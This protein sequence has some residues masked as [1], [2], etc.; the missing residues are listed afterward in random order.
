MTR[1]R[2]DHA[3]TREG[4]QAEETYSRARQLADSVDFRIRVERKIA[5][6]EWLVGSLRTWAIVIATLVGLNWMHDLGAATEM[7]DWWDGRTEGLLSS[8]TEHEITV[9]MPLLLAG[10]PVLY[11]IY[12]D[13]KSKRAAKAATEEEKA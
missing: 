11:G 10:L 12:R 8:E 3:G 6:L 2:R 7:F 1:D 4:D 9:M 13:R 5:R